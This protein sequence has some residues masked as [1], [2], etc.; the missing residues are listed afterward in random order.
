VTA[1]TEDEVRAWLSEQEA[2]LYGLSLSR[3]LTTDEHTRHALLK[4]T[5]ALLDEARKDKARLDWLE[6]SGC[7]VT[8]SDV[9]FTP[10]PLPNLRAAID[11]ARGA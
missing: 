5:L 3:T 7:Y 11:Q 2:F 4:T 9:D 6:A 10:V 1:P 8:T